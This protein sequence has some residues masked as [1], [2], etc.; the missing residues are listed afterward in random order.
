[1]PLA[2]LFQKTRRC[3]RLM[4]FKVAF[5]IFVVSY[6]ASS[7][8]LGKLHK[9]DVAINVYSPNIHNV[10]FILRNVSTCDK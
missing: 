9:A 5:L 1:M 7:V 2:D 4:C 3:K 8:S 10:H 6:T